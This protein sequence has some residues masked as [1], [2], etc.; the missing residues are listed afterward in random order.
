MKRNTFWLVSLIITVSIALIAI[1]PLALAQQQAT[2][3]QTL[4]PGDLAIDSTPENF[5]FQSVDVTEPTT[6]HSYYIN[7]AADP[8]T[9]AVKIHDGR[10]SGGFQ[11]TIQSGDYQKVDD[12][13][14]TIPSSS[15]SIVT[16]GTAINENTAAGTPAAT[17]PLDGDP[18]SGSGDYNSNT[19]DV[20]Q[21]IFQGTAGAA[22]GRVGTYSSFP[23]FR[24]N[25][26]LSTAQGR[27]TN[28]ITYTLT[29]STT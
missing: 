9:T 1:I 11:L 5:V 10:F 27:Y 3:G 12:P 13:T 6:Y 15:L 21:V 20:P 17:A 23:S 4:D 22:E 8:D 7:P 18:A 24:L 29:D 19:L 25:I 26:P 14:K 28:T 2:V 16:S